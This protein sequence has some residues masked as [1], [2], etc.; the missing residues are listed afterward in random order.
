LPWLVSFWKNEFVKL[1]N[2]SGVILDL[3][4]KVGASGFVSETQFLTSVLIPDDLVTIAVG[5]V[6]FDL[7]LLDQGLDTLV[8]VLC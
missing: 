6:E 3:K 5:L 2:G 8:V 4:V 7:E 1:V